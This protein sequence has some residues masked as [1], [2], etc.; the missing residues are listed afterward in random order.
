MAFFKKE[1][2]SEGFDVENIEKKIKIFNAL[3]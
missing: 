1:S 2:V 3:L